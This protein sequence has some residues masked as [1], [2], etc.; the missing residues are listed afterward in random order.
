MGQPRPFRRTWRPHAPN[1]RN[2]MYFRHPKFA[3][4]PEQ[5]VRA[6]LLLQKD[7]LELFEYV[8]PSDNNLACHS[9]RIHALLIRIAIEM[10]ANFRAILIENNYAK[11]RKDMKITDYFKLNHFHK[12]SEYKVKMPVWHGRLGLRQPFS[13][14][15]ND[16]S[17]SWYQ[18]YNNAKHDRHQNFASATFENTI[19]AMC[20]LAVVISSQFYNCDYSPRVYMHQETHNDGFKVCIGDYFEILFPNTWLPAD[21]YDFVWS[22]I[23][24]DA[25]P[26]ARIKFI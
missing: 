2:F 21:L 12:L 20:G 15:K 23:E 5:Y 1:K 3:D 9:Y 26:F 16:H 25:D 18:A 4:S 6:F 17:L 10:E 24:S 13:N 11:N 14:W 22:D 7:M 8:E 19:D